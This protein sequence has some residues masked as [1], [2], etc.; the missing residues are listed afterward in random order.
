MYFSKS[1]AYGPGH[2]FIAVPSMKRE[3]KLSTFVSCCYPVLHR[4]KK[5]PGAISG[6]LNTESLCTYAATFNSSI[7]QVRQIL[8]TSKCW[9]RGGGGGAG[10]KGH[11]KRVDLLWSLCPFHLYWDVI[12]VLDLPSRSF[13]KVLLLLFSKCFLHISDTVILCFKKFYSYK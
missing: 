13:I 7:K 6:I 9:E 10:R 12:W 1:K 8:G 4:C 3:H 5:C 11:E 2:S